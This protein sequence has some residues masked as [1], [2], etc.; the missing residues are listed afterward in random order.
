M[1]PTVECGSSQRPK[2][3]DRRLLFSR[4]APAHPTR[5]REGEL[6]LLT[7][8]PHPRDHRL[9]VLGDSRSDSWTWDAAIIASSSNMWPFVTRSLGTTHYG[10]RVDMNRG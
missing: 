9:D 5:R 10:Q 6:L 4:P 2:H 8:Y 1:S 7:R 3:K